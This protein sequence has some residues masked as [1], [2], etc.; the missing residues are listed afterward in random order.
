M[1]YSIYHLSPNE[2]EWTVENERFGRASLIFSSKE[3]AVDRVRD[4]SKDEPSK[5]FI[6]DK[7]GA[8]EDVIIPE[9]EMVYSFPQGRKCQCVK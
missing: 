1:D 7:D 8:I 3:E 5:V 9:D 2:D 4:L 6:L